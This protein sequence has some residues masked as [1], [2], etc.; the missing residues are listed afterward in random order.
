MNIEHLLNYLL[1]DS[2]GKVGISIESLLRG[3]RISDE[4]ATLLRGFTALLQGKAPPQAVPPSMMEQ[5]AGFAE[6]SEVGTVEE[7][8]NELRRGEGKG[9]AE[10]S[11]DKDAVDGGKVAL[12]EGERDDGEGDRTGEE[13]GGS[14]DTTD[15]KDK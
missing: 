8:W 10:G 12:G 4:M 11:R 6:E 1:A 13:S 15:G 7:A 9:D 5:L 3:E 2:F 14:S